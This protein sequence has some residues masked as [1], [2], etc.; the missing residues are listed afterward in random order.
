MNRYEVQDNKLNTEIVEG[1]SALNALKK[2]LSNNG[3]AY[4]EIVK[5]TS[6]VNQQLLNQGIDP[7][8]QI[9]YMV[10]KENSFGSINNYHLVV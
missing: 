3:I 9:D 4:K 6:A 10:G 8:S 2:F 1:T 5:L 7:C